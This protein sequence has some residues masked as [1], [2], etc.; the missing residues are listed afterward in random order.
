M[1]PILI[2]SY[3]KKRK[4]YEQKMAEAKEKNLAVAPED[5]EESEPKNV[6]YCKFCGNKIKK[7]DLFC[8]EC[9]AKIDIPKINVDEESDSNLE[10]ETELE[11]NSSEE[12]DDLIDDDSK[13]DDDNDNSLE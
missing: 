12:S 2:S 13:L 7:G 10:N 9:G 6:Y 1:G 5:T 8:S 11:D 4:F 3:V